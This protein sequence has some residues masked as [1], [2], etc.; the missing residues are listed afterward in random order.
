MARRN[1]KSIE[2]LTKFIKEQ[3]EDVLKNEVASVIKD[4]QSDMVEVSVYSNYRP[5]TPDR[6]PKVYRRRGREGGL[7]DTKN[8]IHDTKI[9]NNSVRLTVKNVT[10]GSKDSRYS[11]TIISDLVEGGHGTNNKYY[12][13]PTD[14]GFTEPRPFIQDTVDELNEYKFHVHAFKSGLR[15]KGFGV[16]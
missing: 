15:Q 9:E 16:K 1:F 2:E 7:A 6:E 12:D 13:Y 8:M 4:T 11:N 3:S 10:K 5:D 14:S